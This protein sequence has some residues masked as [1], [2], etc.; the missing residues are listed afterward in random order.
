MRGKHSEIPRITKVEQLDRLK[1]YYETEE[2]RC[3]RARLG[4][5]VSG[6]SRSQRSQVRRGGAETARRTVSWVRQAAS[7]V[8]EKCI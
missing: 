7:V 5:E 6:K 8:R 4:S 3:V 2:W 1:T